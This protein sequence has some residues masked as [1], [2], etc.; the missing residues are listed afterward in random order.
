MNTSL[1]TGSWLA[2]AM[3]AACESPSTEGGF[4]QQ[5]LIF[6]R[7]VAFRHASI[8]PGIDA[9]R[10]MAFEAGVGVTATEDPDVF[11]MS[12]LAGY[13]AVVFL[14]TTGDVLDAGQQQALEAFVRGGGGFVG[15]HSAADTEYGWP[16]YGELVGAY[17]E[18]HPPG[19]PT[20]TLLVA[21]P[22]HPATSQLSSPWIRTD[23]WYDLRDLQPGLSILLNIDETTYK[24]P[25]DG[26]EPMPRP[27][28]WYRNFDGG[29]SFYTALGHTSES[30]AE[31]A[32]RAHLWGGITWALGS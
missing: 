32:F 2:V 8:E 7:T 13:D 30:F 4:D 31:P 19:T 11:T 5:I 3:L 21:D 29:R 20:A 9:V 24:A 12:E 16:W 23:E 17:F 27:I 6:S 26:P 1:R 25:A 22:T 15:V 14:S 28:A 10:E 18:S